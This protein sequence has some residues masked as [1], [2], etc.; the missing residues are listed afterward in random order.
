MDKKN[1][2]IVSPHPDDMEI[3]MG[4]TAA[5]L[6]K[7]G[8]NVV[9]LVVTDGRRSTSMGNIS[10]EEMAKRR[11]QEAKRAARILGID[12][13][14]LLGLPD[15][16]T[17]DNR[18]KLKERLEE[19][20]ICLNPLEVFTTHPTIDKHPTH[21]TTSRVVLKTL[22]RLKGKLSTHTIWFYE[23]WTPFEKYN[24]IEDIS[25]EIARKRAAIRAHK[26]QIE[27]KD[28]IEGIMGLN[29][30]RATFHNVNGV[31]AMKYAEVF[32]G[33]SI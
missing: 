24:R 14:I 25:N 2:L 28:Y 11:E 17:H 10:Q 30:Y 15:I 31:D 12:N 1:A 6:L 18:K 16:R 7:N 9:S 22:R 26:S 8:V 20:L 21:R 19:I 23:V 3:G 32:I 4:G 29:R 5:K 33:L 27:Y 13:L